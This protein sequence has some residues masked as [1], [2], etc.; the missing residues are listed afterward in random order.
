MGLFIRMVLY[1]LFSGLSGYG[2]GTMDR[3][4]DLYSVNVTDL[5][6]ILTGVVGFLATFWSSRIAKRSGGRT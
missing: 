4:T 5:A 2:I 6:Q 1:A 3:A